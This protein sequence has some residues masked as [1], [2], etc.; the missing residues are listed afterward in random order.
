MP[1]GP[2]AAGGVTSSLAALR[3]EFARLEGE[4]AQ[5]DVHADQA[6]ARRLGRRYAAL[7]PVV[8]TAGALDTARGDLA[9][10]QELGEQDEA[11]A[12]EAGELAERVAG[13]E[14]ELTELLAPRDPDDAK[15]VLVEIKAGEG[16]EESALFAGDLL[17]MYLRYAERHGWKTE[18]LAARRATWAASRMS[19][20][21]SRRPD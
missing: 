2:T 18:V 10:A 11:F 13:L 3:E 6:R 8:S 16:G 7:A 21:R 9:A 5:P 1:A 4:L 15:D 19:P 12:V 20:W 14:G 17:R